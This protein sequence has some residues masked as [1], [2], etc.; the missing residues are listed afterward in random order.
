MAKGFGFPLIGR[1]SSTPFRDYVPEYKYVDHHKAFERV[2]A[3]RHVGT[4]PNL[5]LNQVQSFILL[6]Q[7]HDYIAGVRRELAVGLGLGTTL[8]EEHCCCLHHTPLVT[9]LEAEYIISRTGYYSDLVRIAEEWLVAP[10]EQ[11]PTYPG[12]LPGVLGGPSTPV[13]SV[14]QIGRE[15]KALAHRRS[16]FLL[17]EHDAGVE[18][19]VSGPWVKTSYADGSAQ[20]RRQSWDLLEETQPLRCVVS[21]VFMLPPPH[22]TRRL[23]L[24]ESATARVIADPTTLQ[25]YYGALQY[26]YRKMPE[27]ADYGF[28]PTMIVLAA[29]PLDFKKYVDSGK[30]ALAKLAIG[31]ANAA[32]LPL[33]ETQTAGYVERRITSSAAGASG[34]TR[35]DR[36]GAAAGD[37]EEAQPP[38]GEPS[39]PIWTV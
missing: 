19:L 3:G 31:S 24:G 12:E 11:A 21:G 17:A 39:A 10:H 1:H 37:G 4:G 38:L 15:M 7:M 28:L 5:P 9:R 32:T 16:P 29:R 34:G 30:V 25:R 26:L 27:K 35:G 6:D 18:R 20:V 22:C 36:R 8:C 2:F 14:P 23:G 33:W 13:R